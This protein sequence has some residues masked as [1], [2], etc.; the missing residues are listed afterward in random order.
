MKFDHVALISKSIKNSIQWYKENLGAEVLYADDTWGYML[1]GGVKIA[2][3]VKQQHP[4]HICFEVNEDF[5]LKNLKNKKFKKH[6]DGT[7][8]YY[9]KDI[10]GNFIEYLK[11]PTQI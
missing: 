8:S 7:E 3:V 4:P 1:V 2:L 11:C 6:R 10:D 9:T 5:I